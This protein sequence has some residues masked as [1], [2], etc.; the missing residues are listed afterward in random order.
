VTSKR[1]RKSTKPKQRY[2]TPSQQKIEAILRDLPS[3]LAF[4]FYEDIGKPSGQVAINLLEFDHILASAKSGK[5]QASLKFHL[6]RGD[7][8]AWIR[9]AIGD[10]ELAD[11]IAKIKPNHRSLARKLHKTVD[12][13][14]NQLKEALIEFSIVPEDYPSRKHLDLVH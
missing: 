10:S 1:K 13:R 6:Q 7:F 14:I 11:K 4:H 9:Q 12:D 8:A 5:D 2:S 3:N